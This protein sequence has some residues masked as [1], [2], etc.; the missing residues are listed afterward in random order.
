M[1]SKFRAG[2]CIALLILCGVLAAQNARLGEY[3][4]I[5]SDPPLA[6]RPSSTYSLRVA[7]QRVTDELA[8]RKID[9]T[10]SSRMLVNAVFVR[11]TEAPVAEL[12]AIS[13]VTRVEYMPPVHRKLDR[14]LPLVNASAAWSALGGAGNAG[15][16]VK[17][18][19]LDTGIDQ[20]HPAF[21][22]SSL[23]VPSGF[24]KGDKN[25]TNQK[26]I[27]AR[28]YVA[29]LPFQDVLATDSRPDDITPRDRS[30]HGTAMA[31]IA[32]GER[33][34]A[35]LA[36]ISGMAP[37][38]FLGNYKIFGSPG[39]NDTT[40]SPVIIQALEDAIGDGM[41][42]VALPVG[43]PA[44]YGPLQ[45]DASCAGT[46]PGFNI[47]ATACDVRAQAIES[48]VHLGLTVVVPA[49]NDGDSAL[50]YPAL[51]SIDTPGTAPAAITAGASTNAHMFYAGVIVPGKDAPTRLIHAVF[52]DG[53]TPTTDLTATL[54]DVSQLQNDGRACAAL[55]PKSLSGEIALVQRGNCAFAI[56]AV[57]AANAGAL[58]MIVVQSAG[59]EL[60]FPPTGVT[61]GGI[62]VVMTGN[63]D[64]A[65]LQN[66]ARSN[67][68]QQVTISP[69]LNAVDSAPDV[70]ATFSSRG[71]VLF[72][73]AIK[74]DLVA[75][76]ADLYTAAQ[77]YDPNGD[78]YDPSG[79]TAVSGTSFAS[80]LVAGAAALVKQVHPSYTPGQIKSA[81]V[82]S[83]SGQ[84]TDNGATARVTAAGG[85]K[86]DAAA[87]LAAPLTIE[88]ATVSFGVLDSNTQFPATAPLTLTNTLTNATTTP[89]RVDIEV[90]PTDQDSLAHVTVS[91]TTLLLAGQAQLT[92]QLTRGLSN[93][94]S[95]QGFV[96][97]HAGSTIL[98]VP[99]LYIVSDANPD[100]LLPLAGSSFDGAVNDQGFF[101][102][103]KVIDRYGAAVT[104]QPVQFNV[105]SGDGVVTAAD[106]STDVV[107]IA[108]ANVDLGS[109]I[110]EQIFTADVAGFHVEFD[111]R[112]RPRPTIAAGG[113][114]NAGSH[115]A[116]K[117]LA[118]GSYAEIYG[119]GL[120][121]TT[122]VASTPYL[123]V[124]LAGVSV[125]FDATGI[126]VP[127]HIF[128]VT[129]GQVDVQI[130]WE[131]QG[132]TSAVMKVSVGDSQS[133]V[134]SVPL[135]SVSPAAFQ[136]PDSAN[137][138]L[139]AAA[140]DKNNRVITTANPALRNQTIS[141]YV[142]GLGAVNHTPASGDP[143]PAQPLAATA[144][145]P[146]VTIGGVKAPVG[147]SGLSPA[148][149]GL[150]QI[151]VMVPPQARAGLQPVVITIN[152]ID[153]QPANLPV[154]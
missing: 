64:G 129:P 53:Q 117:G 6:H 102:I 112:A 145:T 51:S 66:V 17:I 58:A 23:S 43:D 135:A 16:G 114:V 152:G 113:V 89:M 8:R 49:G 46:S 78:V 7:Q 82:N 144:S 101:L 126:S 40:R 19:I 137:S 105:A 93:P 65:F 88:P 91:Q 60:P 95:Y 131:L 39:V 83:A 61:F 71:P 79:Y 151:N 73:G 18:G 154:Q 4:L 123:P 9:I 70:V 68:S 26:V 86:L 55:P 76:G 62:P 106:A 35:P 21:Q 28:S 148:S 38:A 29:M 5:L 59:N 63:S 118:P 108:A 31:M 140:L 121:E 12:R 103:L 74:P 14:A 153:S 116:G 130:P 47:P 115:Q 149:I 33:V 50:N 24:P 81:L 104:S 150:Y 34:M 87:A 84:V 141:L 22:D 37:K 44:V 25:Y 30:G 146:G 72:S 96:V 133:A 127:G 15:K 41:D 80:G 45:T 109:Q 69:T 125:S 90:R 147:F 20:N 138:Q 52:G 120:S 54:R 132:Q 119:A 57:N 77:S 122:D 134:Y 75:P 85:G 136:I 124:S 11:T 36:A 32:A 10:G 92:V 48:A 110:G 94:G 143:T 107:G 142:N 139:V 27:V 42:I 99:Y 13:G 2:G 111:G 56:K 98:R 3:A 128:F 1:S 67:A 100:N 97:L